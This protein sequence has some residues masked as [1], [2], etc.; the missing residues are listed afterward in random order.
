MLSDEELKTIID[1][2]IKFHQECLNKIMSDKENVKDYYRHDKLLL[3][4]K[5]IKD[6]L[7]GNDSI[8]K[9][10]C[11]VYDN[12]D[13]KKNVFEYLKT[14]DMF[15]GIDPFDD[16]IS[17]ISRMNGFIVY[18][19]S[20]GRQRNLPSIISELNHLY[21]NNNFTEHNVYRRIYA[22]HNK[23]ILVKQKMKGY[24]SLKVY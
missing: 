19:M 17:D 11:D 4:M 1:I 23:G 16:N 21:P 15:N 18:I 24:Y 6:R 22:L 13:I 5:Q 2:E 12:I 3:A 7:I 14:T 10:S 9:A 20:D 8:N